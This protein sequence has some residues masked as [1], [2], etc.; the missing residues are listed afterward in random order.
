M[1]IEC[2][3]DYKREEGLYAKDQDQK[4]KGVNNLDR[5][6]DKINEAHNR[7]KIDNSY[8]FNTLI[9]FILFEGINNNT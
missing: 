9:S 5:L 3:I 7:I 6:A 4:R 8:I 1:E 2:K